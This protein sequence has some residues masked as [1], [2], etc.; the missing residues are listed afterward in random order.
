MNNFVEKYNNNK[1]E[2]VKEIH[3]QVT[4]TTSTRRGLNDFKNLHELK[5]W[6]DKQ[7]VLAAALGYTKGKKQE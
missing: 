3:M 7:P 6:L 2:E 5:I 4:Y 1:M